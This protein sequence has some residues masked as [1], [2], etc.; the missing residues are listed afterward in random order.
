MGAATLAMNIPRRGGRTRS[1]MRM[2]PSTETEVRSGCYTLKF[3]IA[4]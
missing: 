2:Y 4:I 1:V 3:H